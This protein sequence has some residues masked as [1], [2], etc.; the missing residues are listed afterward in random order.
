VTAVNSL[1]LKSPAKINLVLDILGKRPDGFHELNTLF[2]RIDLSDEM[3]LK[4]NLSGKI[5]VFCSHP[6][7]P[8]GKG[9]LTYKIARKVQEDHGIKEGV[10]IYITKNIPVAAGLGGGSS[11]GATI[12]MGLNRLWQLKLTQE[13][14]LA[15]ASWAGSDISFFIYNTSYAI[16]TGRGEEIAV[17]PCGTKLWHVLV[18]PKVKMLT[19]DVFSAFK[20]KLTK[21]YDHVNI[22]LPF[23]RENRFEQIANH[24]SNDLQV[25]ILRLRP[26][27]I[28]LKKKLLD[29]GGLGV[30]FSGSGPSVFALAE[31]QK[32]AQAIRAK[33]D[34]RYTQVFVVRTL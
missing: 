14:L 11:N 9:N 34:Q 22:L 33:F 16:G 12:L 32:H 1:S 2:E 4:N 23:L 8:K 7:V 15:Y 3:T 20:L 25:A 18:T 29:A 24:F 30:S 19:K 21:K 26:D 31:S 10:D 17:V 27:F 28:H 5:R 13:E 6:H